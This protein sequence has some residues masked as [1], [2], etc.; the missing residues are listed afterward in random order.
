MLTRIILCCVALSP[1][2]GHESTC[3]DANG[4]NVN[5]RSESAIICYFVNVTRG[6]V[7]LGVYS[8]CLH[9][10]L[11]LLSTYKYKIHSNQQPLFSHIVKLPVP[12]QNNGIRPCCICCRIRCY[13]SVICNYLTLTVGVAAFLA[14]LACNR[15][16]YNKVNLL[17]PQYLH[18]VLGSG[19]HATLRY[20]RPVHL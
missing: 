14:I 3:K 19:L 15:L 7:M 17:A 6:E 18:L 5:V 16:C 4:S 1:V 12:M 20:K 13:N 8:S 2:C 11:Y 9:L 10:D